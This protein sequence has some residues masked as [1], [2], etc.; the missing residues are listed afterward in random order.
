MGAEKVFWVGDNKD[1]KSA[2]IAGEFYVPGQEIPADKVDKD[3][4]D[5]WIEKGMVST[6]KYGAPVIVKDTDAVKALEAENRN[7]NAKLDAM[8]ALEKQNAELK[9][10]LKKAQS[11][12]KDD[13]VKALE[14]DVK[15]KAAL[16]E[17]Q[18][19]RITELEAEVETLTDPGKDAGG[20]GAGPGGA[21]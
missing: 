11:A 1:E 17:K 9:K 10:S 15:E 6:G 13:A 12:K 21:G 14:A 2:L 8:P 5:N 7:L 20:D 3:R 16:I 18:A 4:L 19:A